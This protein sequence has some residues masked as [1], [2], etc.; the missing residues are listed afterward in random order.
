MTTRID[1]LTGAIYRVAS[2]VPEAGIM[3]NQFLI[4]SEDLS[5]A[6]CE[7]ESWQAIE[8]QLS[9]VRARRS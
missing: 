2:W 8:L 1:H 9:R 4:V 7:G 6:M 5:G 3:F